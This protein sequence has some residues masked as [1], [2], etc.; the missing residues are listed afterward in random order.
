M[1]NIM[2][3]LERKLGR[4]VN[5]QRDPEGRVQIPLELAQNPELGVER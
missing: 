2:T 4:K 3:M 1:V 5:W